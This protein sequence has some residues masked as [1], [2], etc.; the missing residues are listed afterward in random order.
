MQNPLLNI[1]DLPPFGQVKVE[2]IEP[3]LDE[4]LARNRQCIAKVLAQKDDYNWQNS[5]MPMEEADDALS[6]MW[7]VVSHLNGVVNTPALRDAYNACLPKLTAFSSELGQHQG[8]YQLYKTL[9]QS[10]D[11]DQLHVGQQ[12]C[13]KHSLR[14]FRLSG[15]DLPESAQA[16]LQ[17]VD[18]TLSQLS[19]EFEEHVLDATNHWFCHVTDEG[20]VAGLPAVALDT[21]RAVAKSRNL[22][23]FVLTLDFPCY[24]A[25]M[26][27]CKNRDLREQLYRAYITRASDQGPD[28]GKWDNSDVMVN[29]LRLR[30]EKATLLGFKQYAELSLQR[31]MCESTEQVM[32]F[33]QDLAKRSVKKAKQEFAELQQYAA[34]DL[35][36][37]QPWDVGFY[38]EALR[39][40]R[41]A[42]SQETLRPY[43][44]I[45][46]VL[47]GLFTITQRLYGVEISERNDIDT[48]HEDVRFFEIKNQQGQLQAQFYLDLYARANKRG[49]AW[50]DD[51]RGRRHT[52]SG[53]EQTPV[54]YLVCNFNPA[55]GHRPPLLTHD[56]VETLFHEFGHGLHHML[57]QIDHP[58]V[59]GINGVPWDAVELPSQFYENWCWQ[60]DALPLFSAHYETGEPLPQDLLDKMLAGKNFQSAMQMVRQLEFA[61]FD[62]RIHLAAADNEINMDFINQILAD[63]RAEVA[64]MPPV[65]FNRFAHSF[66]H[67]FAGGYAAGYYGYK[68]AEVLSSDAFSLFEE[69]GIFDQATADKF[70][71]TILAQGGS[72][73]PMDLFVEFR[74][75]KPSLDALLRHS[76]IE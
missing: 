49:G 34:K 76:G 53:A 6:R 68:W 23:G 4:L 1:S 27:H 2:D 19:A 69:Q 29:I 30:Q 57:T 25:V 16:R 22:T 70:L 48:W 71:K 32:D 52:L 39:Q 73:E 28:G 20:A 59:A 10:P 63:V 62:F 44:P 40:E 51:C 66:S 64:V 15:I 11:F 50:M 75:R 45:D 24:Y 67:I 18:K 5:I 12:Q 31:K 41:Y 43:F 21:A 61:L 56:E 26:T 72:K 14:D 42:L 54:A 47:S 58:D 55:S 38:A 3:A 46:K 35:A 60:A 36:Q 8:L 17:E 33:L 9:H 74:G 65:A 13:I 37:L 7:A